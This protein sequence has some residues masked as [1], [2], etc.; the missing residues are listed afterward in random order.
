ML[1]LITAVIAGATTT[2]KM[3]TSNINLVKH[4]FIL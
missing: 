4:W 1:P 3:F 2:I